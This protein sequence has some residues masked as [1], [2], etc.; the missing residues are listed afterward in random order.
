MTFFG[1][2]IFISFFLNWFME[3]FYNHAQNIPKEFE[4][5]SFKNVG[6]DKLLME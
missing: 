2:P 3:P 6:G 5:N 1:H 4:V